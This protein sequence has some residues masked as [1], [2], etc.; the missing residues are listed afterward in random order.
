MT[1]KELMEVCTSKVDMFMR[2]KNT[3]RNIQIL[4]Y[5]FNRVYQS[6]LRPYLNVLK[7]KELYSDNGLVAE[8]K[9][10]KEFWRM[11]QKLKNLEE[12]E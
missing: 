9:F 3:G 8:I 5:D 7:V 2:D 1:I 12:E 10:N 4:I 6:F 11:H